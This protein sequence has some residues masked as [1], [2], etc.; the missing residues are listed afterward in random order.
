MSL[1]QISLVAVVMEIRGVEISDL[2]VP[3]NNTLVCH[4]SFYTTVCLESLISK[5]LFYAVC[6][7]FVSTS[8]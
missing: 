6:G 5:H 2:T 3:A 7:V 8:K 4:T 1:V